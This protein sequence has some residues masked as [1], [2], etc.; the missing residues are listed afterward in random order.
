MAEKYE[1][2]FKPFNVTTD[3]KHYDKAA[4]IKAA[5]A[6]IAAKV[7]RANYIATVSDIVNQNTTKGFITDSQQNYLLRL[8][9]D[10]LPE[11]KTYEQKFIEWY[12]VRE[13]IQEVY[14]YSM[15]SPS[16]VY[17]IHPVTNEYVSKGAEGW[18]TSWESRPADARMFWKMTN[19]WNVR[20]FMAVNRD[21]PFEEGDL[22][23]LRKGNV[24]NW[25]YD[26]YYDGSNT[27]DKTT[28]RIGTVM[29]M[30]NEVHRRSR[31]GK[32]SRQINV[33]WIGSS[34]IKG[35]PERILKLHERKSRKRKA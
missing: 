31:A 6:F 9:H 8:I 11:Y 29:Q 34:E 14:K 5:E 16:Y 1:F 13:D 7:G 21:T 19:D 18:D 26:P 20:K 15:S 27:P 23:V 17:V 24:G 33:L 30:T 2:D 32:G 35:V 25:R 4:T 12:D 22:V 3:L 10:T 28:D